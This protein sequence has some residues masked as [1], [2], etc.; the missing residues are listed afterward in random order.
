[1]Y[2]RQ[3]SKWSVLAALEQGT[4][5]KAVVGK[6][7][8]AE[9]EE[10]VRRF[11]L[12]AL[13]TW[14]FVDSLA[15]RLRGERV[16]EVF[17]GTGW[18]AWALGTRGIKV[19]ATDNYSWAFPIPPRVPVIKMDATQAVLRYRNWA[20]TLLMCWPPP[21]LAPEAALLRWPLGKKVVYIGE[22][23][24]GCT[25]ADGFFDLFQ[26]T[27]TIPIPQWDGIHDRCYIGFRRPNPSQQ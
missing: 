20:T 5:P 10:V 1:M 22:P 18:L 15:A 23:R 19:V 21:S 9:R 27:E 14:S 6:P 24:G 17:A 25:A 11:G 4:L 3:N 12:W 16:L 26:E 7:S 2:Q 13:L 8:F